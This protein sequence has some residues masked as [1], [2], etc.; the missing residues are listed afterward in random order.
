V[1]AN[2]ADE[3]FGRDSARIWRDSFRSEAHINLGENVLWD[4]V[5]I[6]REFYCSNKLSPRRSIEPKHLPEQSAINH[7]V[8]VPAPAEFGWMPPVRGERGDTMTG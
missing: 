1:F 6:E 4:I 2:V 3:R 8:M 5:V 7:G